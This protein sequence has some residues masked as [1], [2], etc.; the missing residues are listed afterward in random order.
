MISFMAN[1]CACFSVG[2]FT[3]PDVQ[4]DRLRRLRSD[5]PPLPSQRTCLRSDAAAD[6]SCPYCFAAAARC[7]D[8]EG[9][10]TKAAA[11][12]SALTRET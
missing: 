6:R 7:A 9:E 3:R 10:A 2:M 5:D 4:Q 8:A 12:R 1:V 11:Q